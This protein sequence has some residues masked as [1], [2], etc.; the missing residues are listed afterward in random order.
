MF[1]KLTI[2]RHFAN[3]HSL[4]MT[5]KYCSAAVIINFSLFDVIINDLE[6]YVSFEYKEVPVLRLNLMNM[7]KYSKYLNI[8]SNWIIQVRCHPP[9]IFIALLYG[10]MEYCRFQSFKQQIN[11][12]L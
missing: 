8:P 10:K 1:Q 2:V 6:C 5:K 12:F 7:F 4:P 11:A 9:G 3:E